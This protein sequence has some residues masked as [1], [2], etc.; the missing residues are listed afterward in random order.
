MARVSSQY[1]CQKCGATSVKWL[2]KCPSCGEWNTYVEE[3][4]SKSKSKPLSVRG[5]IAVEG[6]PVPEPLIAVMGEGPSRIDC[7]LPEVNRVLGGG[8]VPGALVLLGGEPGIGKSTLALQLALSEAFSRVLYVS[9]EESSAQIRLRAERIGA[10][11]ERCLVLNETRVESILE[12]ADRVKPAFMVVDSI[13]TLFSEELESASGTV[14]QIRECASILLRYAKTRGVPILLIG[15]ITKEGSLAGPKVLEHIVDT[16]L[17]FEG[18]SLHMYRVLRSLK[19]RFGATSELALFEMMGRGLREISNPS[20]LLL[21]SRARNSSGVAVCA[22]IDG[23]RSLLVEVQALVSSA[24]Y[25]TSQRQTTG[26]DS[27]RLNMLLAVMEKRAGLRL[28]SKDVF[29]NIA[30]G[31]KLSDPAL[32][33]AVVAAI[34]SS[35]FDVVLPFAWCFTGEIGLSGEVRTVPRLGQR[36]KEALRLGF[37]CLWG[38]PPAGAHQQNKSWRHYRAVSSVEE[39]VRYILRNPSGDD[40]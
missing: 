23:T 2:G 16:V 37:D 26:F 19:N 31:I 29:L 24:A 3:R 33:L 18:D 7:G 12:Q 9:G 4:V 40:A 21:S 13:Q 1:V 17:Q 8:L 5:M 15:H 11:S 14:G 22:A 35:A 38:P 27:K 32:D 36:G 6:S 30:G 34:L 39:F 28:Q 25:G 20:E 10:L